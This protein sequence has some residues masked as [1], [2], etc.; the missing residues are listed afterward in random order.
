MKNLL[1]A[2]FVMVLV[3]TGLFA[4]ALQP[5]TTASSTASPTEWHY[6]SSVLYQGQRLRWDFSTHAPFTVCMT[7]PTNPTD[8]D[9]SVQL[10]TIEAIQQWLAVLPAPQ[11]TT[12]QFEFPNTPACKNAQLQ[13][14]FLPTLDAHYT[15][16]NTTETKDKLGF[17]AGITTPVF[18][19]STGKLT[20]M[21]MN[22]ALNKPTGV[23]Q[24]TV[25]LKSVLLH[26]VG[27]ALGLL[28]HSPNPND[29]MA[30]AYYNR[31]GSQ[32]KLQL[33]A[34]DKATLQALY[35]QPAQ[36]SNTVSGAMLKTNQAI[37]NREA[38]LPSLRKEAQ[39]VGIV[40]QWQH[41]GSALLWL[42]QQK[43]GLSEGKRTAYLQEAVQAFNHVLTLQPNRS[44]VSIQL[45]QAYQLLKQLEQAQA[46]LAK[47]IA[48]NPLCT[49]CYLEQAWVNAKLKQWITVKQA[50]FKAR[51]VDPRVVQQPAYQKIEQLL[52]VSMPNADSQVK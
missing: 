3:G 50:L 30:V 13:L 20:A 5:E 6:L 34:A 35:A 22:I 25:L 36:W 12:L 47:A 33:S 52:L 11:K 23:P 26:E 43:E 48:V 39:T 31:A 42:G 41:L 19:P 38:T 49:N 27:H 24:S 8:I 9:R 15:A 40:V 45:A 18:S 16:G 17:T 51:Q 4:F 32:A 28:G 10:L 46:V 2:F 1:I 14:A 44:T 29:V 7:V 21:K 37:T